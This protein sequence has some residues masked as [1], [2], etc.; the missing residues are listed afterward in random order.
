LPAAASALG[1]LAG[2]IDGDRMR[3]LN[4]AVEHQRMSP[5]G[6]A[7]AFLREIGLG[8]REQGR[9]TRPASL[10]ALLWERRWVTLTLTGQHLS[11]TGTAVVAA[12]LLGVPLGIAASRR[13]RLAAAALGTAGVL[14]TI[15][16]I[17]LLA[18]MLPLFGVGALPATV[19]L[20]LYGLLPILRNTVAGLASVDRMLIEVGLGLG[21]R[22]HQ[23]LWHVELPLAAPVILAGIRTSTVINIGTATLAAFIG[24]GGLGD[25]IVT[26]LTVT[27]VNLVL[28][29]ALPAAALAVGADVALAGVER[30]ATPKGLRLG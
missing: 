13:P 12:A 28:S 4:F 21:M 26:G 10:T 7:A 2:R 16:S 11:L 25:P 30:L 24:A 17:A 5:A 23:V 19:A 18:F 8:T 1:L 6:A 9:S 20:F 27:D 15:P 29:G 22:R 3:R 14:Q